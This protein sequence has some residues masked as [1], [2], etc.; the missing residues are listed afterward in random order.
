MRLCGE[1]RSA[2]Q[3]M[4]STGAPANQIHQARKRM[5][6]KQV[7]FNVRITERTRRKWKQEAKKRGMQL[8]QFVQRAVERECD[9]AGKTSQAGKTS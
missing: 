9:D 2:L 3:A 5:P 1:W 8:G 6:D 4:P 7:M